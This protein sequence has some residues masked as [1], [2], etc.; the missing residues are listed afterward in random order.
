M[1]PLTVWLPDPHPLAGLAFGA[2]VTVA[3]LFIALPKVV[4]WRSGIPALHDREVS[5]R[6]IVAA[7]GAIAV[8]GLWRPLLASTALG[9]GILVFSAAMDLTAV[10]TGFERSEGAFEDALA[11]VHEARADEA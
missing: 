8:L 1:R 6:V 9:I 4:T 10:E 3:A 7:A 2:A 5:W 11:P